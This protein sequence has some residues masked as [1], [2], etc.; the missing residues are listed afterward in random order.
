MIL[1]RNGRIV[2]VDDVAKEVFP[3]IK[4][5]SKNGF[6][7]TYFDGLKETLPKTPLTGVRVVFLDMELNTAG[8]TGSKD[9]SK[10]A[11]T[12]NVFRNIIDVSSN[13]TYLVAIWSTHDELIEHFWRYVQEEKYECRFIGI[14]IDKPKCA[15]KGYAVS[16]IE[17]EIEKSLKDQRA[18]KFFINWENIVHESSNNIVCDFS[19]FWNQEEEWDKKTLGTF[20]SLARAYAGQTL[21]VDDHKDIIRN[22]MFAFNR[23]FRDSLESNILT[24]IDLD[25]SFSDI[26]ENSDDTIIAKI[27]SK[28]HISQSNDITKPGN[29]Y[30]EDDTSLL[31]TLI[32]DCFENIAGIDR[33]EIKLFSCE[34][35]PTCD[36]VQNKWRVNRILYGL[37]VPLKWDGKI[38]KRTD[39]LYKTP[40]LSIDNSEYKII[41]D[42]RQLKAQKVGCLDKEKPIFTL[43]HD[44]IVDLQ[45]KI[46]AHCSRPGMISL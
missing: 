40:K 10:A 21:D 2:V 27:N 35:S 14:I 19:S 1:P 43:R 15:S 38:K 32:S 37:K 13:N 4:S 22:A 9:K 17:S 46:A 44:L 16:V 34:V 28:L 30:L 24:D 45:H 39:Y 42:L 26:S 3:L 23:S 8:Y 12:A 33:S 18:F 5:L 11:A 31:D 36:F 25:I 20:I 29:V 41:F 6:A 7:V